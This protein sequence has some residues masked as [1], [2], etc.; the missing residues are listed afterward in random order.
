MTAVY[1]CEGPGRRQLLLDQAAG[2]GRI[3]AVDYVIVTTGDDAP[4]RFRQRLLRIRFLFT[5]GVDGL[6]RDNVRVLGGVR[7]R[8][9]GV[10]WAVPLSAIPDDPAAGDPTLEPDERDYLAQL[11][12]DTTDHGH[13]LVVQLDAYGDFSRYRLAIT[14]PSG[15]GP[16]PGFDVRHNQVELDFK[17][18]CPTPFDCQVDDECSPE[19]ADDPPIDYLA[20]DFASFRRLMFE[21]MALTQP[22]ETSQDPATTRAAVVEVL[23][24][25]ADHASYLLD[26]VNTEAYLPYARRRPSIRRHARLRDYTVHE[27]CNARVFVHLVVAPSTNLAVTD[28]ERPLLDV[29]ATFLT[30]VPRQDTVVRAAGRADALSFA[31]AVFEAVAPVR[32]L[33]DAH[34]E[35]E[36]HTWGDIDCCLPAGATRATLEDPTGRLRLR[37]GD[38]LVLEEIRDRVTRRRADADPTRRHVVRLVEVGEATVDPL[39]PA[40]TP[41]TAIVEVRWHDD[42]ALPFPLF[43]SADDTVVAVARANLVL[44]D[45]GRSWQ[46]DPGS[47]LAVEPYGNQ[48]NLRAP[49]TQRHLTHREAY[50][51]TSASAGGAELWLS[52]SRTVAQDVRRAEPAIELHGEGAV[53][54]PRPDLLGSAPDATEF[55]VETEDDGGAWLRFGDGRKGRRPAL[56]TNLGASLRLG[57]GPAGNVGAETIAHILADGGPSVLG[58]GSPAGPSPV[59]GEALAAIQEVR[60]PVPARG[61]TR[62]EASEDV[63]LYAPHAFRRQERAVTREDWAEVA[64]R[65]PAVQRAVATIEWTGSW[66]VVFVSVDAVAGHPVAGELADDVRAHLERYRLAGYEL[67]VR[68]PS[69]VALDIAMTVCVDPNHFVADV[70]ARLFREFSTDDL[71]DGRRGYFHP[72]E[73]SFGDDIYLSSIVARASAVPGVHWVDLT[74]TTS[75]PKHRFERRGVSARNELREGRIAIGRLEIARCDN[76]RNAPDNGEIRFFMEGGA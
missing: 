11:R 39:S 10:T 52:A 22:E 63:R 76:D 8:D 6:S 61:G 58:T 17:V 38:F 44:C 69:W 5:E 41:P 67:Q 42:D 3:N 27:G 46:T 50:R 60:N 55:V 4:E 56:G 37:A 70:E 21:R 49:L 20:R 59:R 57:T 34:N 14:E 68:P 28:D 54:L 73:L 31:P 30:R 65:H 7:V 53:W 47:T 45:H 74:P 43:V 29:G 71:E 23:A 18:G 15:S 9:P 13:W 51:A 62:P 66:Y 16:P 36:L 26:A 19:P 75:G 12:T 1:R 32:T 72:D 48:G 25:A 33:V 35:I 64:S 2:P 24:Y 40:G